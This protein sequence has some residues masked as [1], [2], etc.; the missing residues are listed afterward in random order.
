MGELAGE[1]KDGFRKHFQNVMKAREAITNK[2][3]TKRRLAGEV[4][5]PVCDGGKLKYSIASNGHIHA[6]CFMKNELP[7]T[8]NAM[9]N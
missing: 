1:E 7:L 3:G 4:D 9:P 5:C 2:E 8:N 6:G